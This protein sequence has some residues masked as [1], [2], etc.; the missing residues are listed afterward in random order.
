MC[1]VAQQHTFW[2]TDSPGARVS[3]WARVPAAGPPHASSSTTPRRIGRLA[4][5]NQPLAGEEA[6][7]RSEATRVGG[8]QVL[9]VD[10]A[11]GG[12]CQQLGDPTTMHTEQVHPTPDYDS[13]A[14]RV[15]RGQAALI[16][17][18]WPTSAAV[19]AHC[20]SSSSTPAQELL[21]AASICQPRRH[22]VETCAL[23]QRP[24]HRSALGQRVHQKRTICNQIRSFLRAAL[25]HT[26]GW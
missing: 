11:L 8:V 20:S 3:S 12:P 4:Q 13:L 5:E 21:R 6:I 14:H 7:Q 23:F 9:D 25:V 17:D 19:M 24:A 2:A 22:Q 26:L 16:R 10:S 15:L 1:H 18:A